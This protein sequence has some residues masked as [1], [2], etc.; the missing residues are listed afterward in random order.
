MK[1]V[2]TI[3]VLGL[4]PVIVAALF[5]M[6]FTWPVT[7]QEMIDL[8]Q[9]LCGIPKNVRIKV[10]V[11]ISWLWKRDGENAGTIEVSSPS[12]DESQR[13]CLIDEYNHQIN[14]NKNGHKV[15]PLSAKSANIVTIDAEGV[16]Q[17]YRA[18]LEAELKKRGVSV[19]Q[20]T[21]EATKLVFRTT[22][23]SGIGGKVGSGTE[24]WHAEVVASL[25]NATDAANDDPFSERRLRE[26]SALSADFA[27]RQ[28]MAGAVSDLAA[29]YESFVK[30]KR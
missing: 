1:R 9:A 2:P 24:I 13:K 7:N 26:E 21:I 4:T 19:L 17:V 8:A 5:V 29:A 6:R 18:M 23:K 15:S 22:I 20:S 10:S 16:D 3:L 11:G 12:L 30:G 28:A 25:A 14:G 27:V